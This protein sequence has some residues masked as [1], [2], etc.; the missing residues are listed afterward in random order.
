[1]TIFYAQPYTVGLYYA[2]DNATVQVALGGEL[3]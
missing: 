3:P 2:N 1:M